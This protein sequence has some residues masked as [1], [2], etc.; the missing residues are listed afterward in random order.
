MLALACAY[1]L[2]AAPPAHAGDVVCEPSGPSRGT[3]LY[4]HPGGFIQGKASDPFNRAW[5]QEFAARGYRTRVVDYPLFDIPGAV[6]AARAAAAREPGPRYA[7]GDSSGGTLAA[8]LAVQRRVDGA[9]TFGAV[10]D[11]LAWPRDRGEWRKHHA[12]R[13]QRIAASPARQPGRTASPL[14]LMHDP[15]DEVVPFRHSRRLAYRAAGA[16]LVRVNAQYA[17][18]TWR[19]AHRARIADWLDALPR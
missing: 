9:A 8:L 12:T 7:V 16:R 4:F 6:R 11:L 17:N 3:I 5:C 19:P 2:A 15:D 14:L 1:A 18:H 13:A 10:T